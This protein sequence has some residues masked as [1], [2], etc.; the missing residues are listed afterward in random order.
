MNTAVSEPQVFVTGRRAAV[1][2]RQG[3]PA[4]LPVEDGPVEYGVIDSPFGECMAGI[5]RQG[6]CYLAFMTTAR[7]IVL[8]DLAKKWPRAKLSHAPEAVRALTR[9]VFSHQEP[10]ELA[11][12]LS[13]TAF[14]VSVWRMLMRIPRG[15]TVSYGWVAEQIGRPAAV[16]AVANAVARNA[17][18][19]LV[20]CHRVCPAD[21]S[22]GQ[23]RWGTDRKAAIL[24][25]ERLAAVV[26]F[27]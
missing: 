26:G 2:G 11:M 8:E 14:Q 23:Y 21:G 5:S 18:A 7:E 22:L 20:P 12:H 9:G 25:W 13:G 27:R 15:T 16:R 1:S 3:E 17:L 4:A 19:Y 24:E 10:S 6:I